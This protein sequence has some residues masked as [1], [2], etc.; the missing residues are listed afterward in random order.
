MELKFDRYKFPVFPDALG[1]SFIF[2]SDL[3]KLGLNKR[4]KGRKVNID[5]YKERLLYELEVINQ[6]GFCDYCLIV[7]D[8]IQYAK[9][10][11]I[12]VGPGRGSG[13]GSLVSYVLGITDIDPLNII[14]YLKDFESGTDFECPI[15]IPIFPDN[16][17]DEVIAY[18]ANK[19]GKARVAH[20]SAFGTFGVRLALRDVARVL[21]VTDVVLN[22][23]LKFV[24]EFGGTLTGIINQSEMF[25]ELI[26]ENEVVQELVRIARKLEGLPR[27]ITTHAAGII[28]ADQELVNY[29]PIQKGINNLYQTQFEA[30]D[31]ERIGLVKMDFLGIRNLTIISEVVKLIK[32]KN[33]EFNLNEIPLDDK[34][35]YRMIAEGDTD[36]IFQLESSGMRNVLRG[37]KTSEFNDMSRECSLS[38]RSREMIPSFIKRNSNKNRLSICILIKKKFSNQRRHCFSGTDY[39]D[40]SNLPV[41]HRDGG[42]LRRAIS[43]KLKLF[44]C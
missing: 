23:V 4:L 27:H 19:Y 1:K 16:R 32:E 11:G 15:S 25:R 38:T 40:C 18:V 9:K 44:D 17:R 24:P 20:I 7:Y 33:P 8:F 36:G 39:V 10:N 12:L 30:V 37:L 13:P 21:K 28:I 22:E 29:T 43:K 3:C 14:C 34:T 31:L 41:I 2:L 35:T 42:Y 26:Q 5:K 6:M